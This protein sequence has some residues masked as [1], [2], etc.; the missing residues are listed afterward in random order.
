MHAILVTIQ[1]KMQPSE[2]AQV[3]Q[4]IAGDFQRV[5]GLLMKTWINKGSMLGGFYVFTDEQSAEAY[6]KSPLIE[7]GARGLGEVQVAHFGVLDEAS[8]QTGTPTQ[9][10]MDRRIGTNRAA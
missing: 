7:Q 1:T 3:S 2:L 4:R 9:P 10:L 8:I 5:K 6:L